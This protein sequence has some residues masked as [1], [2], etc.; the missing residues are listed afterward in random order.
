MTNKINMDEI[1]NKIVEDPYKFAKKISI[2]ELTDILKELSS[3]Y[4]NK[5]AL[6]SDEIFDLLKNVLEERD[7]KNKFLKEI[8]TPVSKNKVNLP[9]PMASLNK[10]KPDTQVLE[11]WKLKYLGPYV[12]SDKLDGISGLLYKNNNKFSLYTRGDSTTGQDIS[13][14]VPYLLNKKFKPEKI[15]D[16]TAIRGEI[17]MSKLNF[18][19][20]KDKFKNARNTVAGL[21]NSI[22]FSEEIANLTDFIGYSI[23]HPKM[24]QQEQ[25]E[26]L[27]KWNFPCVTYKIETDINNNMLSEYLIERRTKSNYEVDGIVVID[28]SKIYD[29]TDIN[30]EY[31]FAFKMVLSDQVAEAVILDIEW[32]VTKHGYLKPVAKIKPI[33]LTGVIIKNVTAFNAKYVV[34]NKLGPGST[35]KLVR[36]GDV[37]PHILQV[38]KPSANGK[39]KMP[40]TPFNWNS[41]G[42]DIIVKDIHGACED[43]I[44]VKQ[45]TSFFK[46]LGVKYI[47]EGIIT[48]L[49]EHGYK[50]LKDILNADISELI[51]IDGIGEKLLTKVFENINVAIK[52][53]NLETLMAASNTFGRGFG[54]RKIKVIIKAYPNIL[55]ENW[56]L[57]M[58]KEKVLELSGFDEITASQFANN[59]NKFK[60]FFKEMQNI[61]SIN[62]THLSVPT[63]KKINKQGDIFK[64]QKIIFTGF[65]NKEM[66]DF[67]TNNGG[68]ISSSVSKNTNLLVYSEGEKDTSSKYIKAKELKIPMMTQQE[69]TDKYLKK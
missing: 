14:L 34:D 62:L 53:T 6:V 51:K 33:S 41:T 28:S 17:I 52:N 43:A 31:G 49:V 26:T 27:L 66:E 24:K 9:Y 15:P 45:L 38:L 57:K 13:H 69:F 42:I 48:K 8:G 36:S 55:N 12:L 46:V 56:D 3:V 20:I 10:I 64:D 22:H 68:Q 44:I 63:K 35:I 59:F 1:V 32:N 47:S 29:V 61:K 4:Y 37:I 67:I 2:K 54:V 40:D 23:I 60:D 39:P 25:V 58:I 50:S 16:K 11:D 65:R 30:P 18:E 19:K 5:E 7:P 21:V